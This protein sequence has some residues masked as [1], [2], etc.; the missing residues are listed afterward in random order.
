MS[1]LIGECCVYFLF[2]L[3]GF[4]WSLFITFLYNLPQLCQTGSEAMQAHATA[5]TERRLALRL[6]VADSNAQCSLMIYHEGIL[7][8]A[9]LLNVEL[10]TSLQDTRSLRTQLRDMF[11][12]AQWTCRFTFRGNEYQ[13]VLELDLRHLEPCLVT[14]REAV[15]ATSPE[16]L[17]R[18][19]THHHMHAGC[20]VVSL[21]DV[22][23]D[24]DL[25][26]FT[27][28]RIDCTAMRALVAFN[29]VDL[30]DDEAL[31]QDPNTTSAIRVKRSVDCLLSQRAS[32]M[33]FRAKLRCAGPSSAVNW[34]LRGS[35]GQVFQ[36]VL[37]QTDSFGEYSVLWH[38]PVVQERVPEVT[39]FWEFLST[40]ESKDMECL[41]GS[42]LGNGSMLC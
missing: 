7:A 39:A 41:C 33:P 37:G 24:K 27:F 30:A 32:D 25:G 21:R 1:G 36:V 40:T 38:A 3:D 18:P 28:G 8:V 9:K 42:M 23:E 15:A 14:T 29:E 5:P 26:M 17:R 35:A 34:M 31:Q 2:L 19:V 13:E 12:S 10:T 11:R 4:E 20:P 6:T 16:L 22:T